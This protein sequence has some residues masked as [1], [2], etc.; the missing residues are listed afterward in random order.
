MVAHAK[1]MALL[2]HVLRLFFLHN[3]LLAH[4]LERERRPARRPVRKLDLAVAADPEDLAH[5]EGFQRDVAAD[6]VLV[7]VA[8]RRKEQ[9][10]R[11]A[12]E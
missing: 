7:R 1:E 3:V 5:L 11:R 4:E 2:R 8:A 12:V 9:I 10:E 6:L